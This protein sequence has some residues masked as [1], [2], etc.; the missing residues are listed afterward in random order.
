L[1]SLTLVKSQR[2]G[3]LLSKV[4]EFAFVVFHMACSHDSLDKKTTW[5]MLMAVNLTMALMPL[6]KEM[7][8]WIAS[9]L[10]KDKI[11]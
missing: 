3:F 11:D 6:A 4:L 1:F 2:A 8:A 5:L 9:L 7:G 10:E